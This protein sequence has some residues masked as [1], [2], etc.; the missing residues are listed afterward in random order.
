MKYTKF[1]SSNDI[2]ELEYEVISTDLK[3]YLTRLLAD[4]IKYSN[5]D[6]VPTI[7]LIRQ[8]YFINKSRGLRNLPVY[9]LRS[10]DLGDYQPT[11]YAWHNGEFEIIIRSLNT[12]QFV[13]F[14]GFLIEDGVF[15]IEEVNELLSQDNSSI[16]FDKQDNKI[17][18]KILNTSEIE[19]SIP[20]NAHTNIR[21]LVS[22][23]DNALERQDY[24]LVIHSSASILETMAKHIIGISS[25]ENQPLGS[26]FSRYQQDSSLPEPILKWIKDIYKNRN[27]QPLAG[28]GSTQPHVSLSSIE[29]A[30]LVEM[31]KAF[32]RIEY[33]IYNQPVNL[34]T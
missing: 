31:T 33:L 8:N 17:R 9:I 7:N 6:E 28:H 14:I 13:E 19:A 11:E 2:K 4:K 21:F 30:T 20:D 12:I 16:R 26:F 34:S 29:A 32:V 15:Q 18:V 3:I 5:T 22:R 10:D 24:S 1:L 25:I 23:M 27:T